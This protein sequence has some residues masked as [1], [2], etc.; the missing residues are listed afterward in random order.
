MHVESDRRFATGHLDPYRRGKKE[1]DPPEGVLQWRREAEPQYNNPAV[2]TDADVT[3]GRQ[4][5]NTFYFNG[6][7]DEVA[8]FSHAMEEAEI[9]SAMSGLGDKEL[10]SKP[11]PTDAAADVP[12]DVVLDWVTG[13]F[14]A[15]H[16]VYFGASSSDVADATRA[17]P[18]GVLVGQ[19]QT[20]AT[21]DPDGLLDFE[22]T[23]YWRVDEVNAAPDNTIFEGNVWSFTT[24][25]VAY[26]IEG[27]IGRQQC[28]LPGRGRP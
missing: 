13:E 21:Y 1:S 9:L 11:N 8:L 20:D 15:T 5:N 19:G 27:R 17:N 7:I 25:P 24:E 2:S 14:A 22:T 28:G 4:S 26:P 3:I 23:Y 16:D 6:V 10:A 12:P 18:M